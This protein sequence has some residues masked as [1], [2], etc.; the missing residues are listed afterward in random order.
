MTTSNLE[1]YSQFLR[2]KSHRF[3]IRSL[4]HQNDVILEPDAAFILDGAIRVVRN[5]I[6]GTKRFVRFYRGSCIPVKPV[7]IQGYLERVLPSF[8]D[9]IACLPEIV[10]KVE[11]IQ[12]TL[13]DILK[14]MFN[15]LNEWKGYRSVWRFNKDM[16][17]DKFLKLSP[18]CV[19]FDEKLLFYYNLRRTIESAV[20]VRDFRCVRLQLRPLKDGILGHI[21]EWIDTLG[22]LLEQTAWERLE[23]ITYKV[24]DYS[25]RLK[26]L[27]HSS[28]I[29]KTLVLIS[30]IWD[31]SLEFE[32]DYMDIQERCRTLDMYGIK[33]EKNIV[34]LSADLPHTWNTLY[35][36]SKEIYFR[37]HGLK[38]KNCKIV[39]RKVDRLAKKLEELWERFRTEGPSSESMSLE[40]GL[41]SLALFRLQLDTIDK[42]I[43]ELNEYQRVL[44]MPLTNF[45]VFTILKTEFAHLEEIYKVFQELQET[46]G[47]I[48]DLTCDVYFAA[49]EKFSLTSI[50]EQII[51]LK[52]RFGKHTVLQKLEMKMTLFATYQKIIYLLNNDKLRPRH[53]L[54]LQ[55]KTGVHT[56]EEYLSFKMNTFLELEQSTFESV[57]VEVIDIA[58]E[59][60]RIEDE[61]T[62]IR[63]RWE[64]RKFVL[65]REPISDSSSSSSKN[66]SSHKLTVIN[67]IASLNEDVEQDDIVIDTMIHSSKSAYFRPDLEKM[68]NVLAEITS[69]L[70]TWIATQ[71]N[72]LVLAR[73]LLTYVSAD[74]REVD[75]IRGNFEEDFKLYNKLME[76]VAKKPIVS[77]CCLMPERRK[78]LRDYKSKFL[79]HNMACRKLIE[80]K[81]KL[82]PRL[83]FLSDQEALIL[84]GG[85]AGGDGDV[86]QKVVRKIL[87]HGFGSLVFEAQKSDR[88]DSQETGMTVSNIESLNG[89]CLPIFRQVDCRQPTDVWLGQLIEEM[90][91][92][93]K[94]LMRRALKDTISINDYSYETYVATIELV[95][96]ARFNILWTNE[97]ENIFE[98]EHPMDQIKNVFQKITGKVA[99]LCK[100]VIHVKIDD[101][102]CRR[103]SRNLLNL[104]LSKRNQLYMFLQKNITSSGDFGWKSSFRLIWRKDHD[105]VEARQGFASQ[106]FGYEYQAAMTV[107]IATEC[108]LKSQFAMFS[109]LHEYKPIYLK[110]PIYSGKSSSVT[111]L[112]FRLGRL[113][114]FLD[115][116][117][118]FGPQDMV[119]SLQGL[120]RANCWAHYDGVDLLDYETLSILTTQLQQINLAQSMNLKEFHLSGKKTQLGLQTGF[121][122]IS[123]NCETMLDSTYIYYCTCVPYRV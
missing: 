14:M 22:K 119:M 113:L 75:D 88:D 52:E 1:E 67:Q 54:I 107:P 71:E 55:E 20:D 50:A 66:S 61:L 115:L 36:K 73:V 16:T 29:E 56:E 38:E 112:A 84:L 62:V 72:C 21:D 95:S 93:I 44:K 59:E 65:T 11:V 26:E 3:T 101:E 118:K 78:M 104:L 6:D 10:H 109:S 105:D 39:M 121:F 53:W 27:R 83:S 40:E 57:I 96:I 19:D 92:T 91:R 110:G 123:R 90:R 114:V 45:K 17:C 34:S 99:T 120:C 18:T 5:L 108:T 43:V 86:F 103:K 42:Q 37:I 102:V 35:V 89:E 100:E 47:R 76:E 81:Q 51:R 15:Y 117:S 12:N 31:M 79:A 33:S 111:E 80:L 41:K 106:K 60:A 49:P 64:E 77:K 98:S 30:D 74:F 63:L 87:G 4:L 2:T 25:S 28:E 8:Y 85:L 68:K 82:L 94:N 32:I 97:V 69:I 23:K 13:I 46:T 7:Y 116:N 48:E 58:Q 70:K 122:F 24:E 9:E